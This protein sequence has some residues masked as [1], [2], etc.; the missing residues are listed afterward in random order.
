MMKYENWIKKLN[1]YNTC[2]CARGDKCKEPDCYYSVMHFNCCQPLH[3]TCGRPIS[4]IKEKE[5]AIKR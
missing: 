1:A 3:F 4:I 2:K 5:N